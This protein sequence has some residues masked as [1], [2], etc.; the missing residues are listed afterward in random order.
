M[1]TVVPANAGESAKQWCDVHGLTDADASTDQVDGMARRS[2]V[3]AAGPCRS[4]FIRSRVMG[5]GTPIDLSGQGD[6]A[7]GA[8]MPH[9]LNAGHFVHMAYGGCP[10]LGL[11][12]RLNAGA[13]H[14]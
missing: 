5:H 12:S 7:V 8:A 1:P 3:T 9:I 10:P 11:A 2:G 13:C 4:S 14:L 6:R